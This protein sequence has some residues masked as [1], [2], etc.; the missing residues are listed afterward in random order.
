MLLLIFDLLPV[1][2]DQS[3]LFLFMLASPADALS[4][5]RC[6]LLVVKVL[7]LLLENLLA[8][9]SDIL[10][11]DADA[12]VDSISVHLL[13]HHAVVVALHFLFLQ[14]FC[15]HLRQFYSKVTLA[16][17][18]SLN[19]VV[20]ILQRRLEQLFS[21]HLFN[22][23]LLF[24]PILLVGEVVDSFS[25]LLH[26]LQQLLV[27]HVRFV[28]TGLSDQVL[29]L[30]VLETFLALLHKDI[31][32]LDFD[33]LIQV[34]FLNVSLALLFCSLVKFDLDVEQLVETSDFGPGLLIA[35]VFQERV[36]FELSVLRGCGLRHHL[37]VLARVANVIVA[38]ALQIERATHAA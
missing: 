37:S 6:L 32:L 16:S 23:L 5:Q 34:G 26:A 28:A 7:L 33:L 8:A 36:V 21:F 2:I 4:C 24:L 20:V 15:V 11:V 17:F 19:I 38:V 12:V 14:V 22:A 30:L 3:E 35:L 29:H 9:L 27:F 13:L 31:V 25:F 1:Q 18:F 10:I